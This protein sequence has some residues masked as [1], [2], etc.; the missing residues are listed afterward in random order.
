MINP[1]AGADQ[2]AMRVTDRSAFAAPDAVTVSRYA[3][4]FA[5]TTA[6]LD[7]V[8][9]RVWLAGSATK[10]FA[11]VD[12]DRLAQAMNWWSKRRRAPPGSPTRWLWARPC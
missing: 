9:N 4:A 10:A 12:A 3:A 1:P 5:P 8:T 7:A 6:P 2:G 11:L